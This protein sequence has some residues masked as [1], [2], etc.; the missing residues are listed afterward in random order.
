LVGDEFGA[1]VGEA[2]EHFTSCSLSS[3]LSTSVLW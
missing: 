2:V 3:K 1:L